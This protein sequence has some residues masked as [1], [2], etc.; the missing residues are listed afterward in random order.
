MLRILA[1]NARGP[2]LAIVAGLVF[3]KPALAARGDSAGP[4]TVPTIAPIASPSPVAAPSPSVRPLPQAAGTPVAA[5]AGA[6]APARRELKKY[7]TGYSAKIR[8]GANP[9]AHLADVIF[10]AE[11]L[12]IT[13]QTDGRTPTEFLIEIRGKRAG[14]TRR[15]LYHGTREIRLD[16]Q[17]RFVYP[18]RLSAALTQ[19][20]LQEVLVNG[21]VRKE[22]IQVE[23]TEWLAV[24][25]FR[26][27]AVTERKAYSVSP[28]I[29]ITSL[30][31]AQDRMD[32]LSEILL[33]VKLSGTLSLGTGP[34][35]LGGNV[36]FNALPLK[37]D[38]NDLQLRALGAN[39]RLGYALPYL[40]APWSLKLLGGIYFNTTFASP[41]TFGYQNVAGPQLFPVLSRSFAD[42]SVLGGY[43]KFSPV[44]ASF[45]LLSFSSREVA[46]GLFY[47]FGS[48][49]GAPLS[50]SL[51]Y[52][53]L[54]LSYG[55]VTARS[56]ALTLGGAINF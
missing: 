24:R 51:D 30:S 3:G 39:L 26:P 40:R 23:V 19:L 53:D 41:A 34:F 2:L 8:R 29:G 10:D 20:T 44:A 15:N 16:E 52:A 22:V 21:E 7:P 55:S 38:R 33:T 36:F 28:G 5:P 43:L 6:V 25:A 27:G 31:Y 45:S 32:S 46:G 47:V 50:L 54:R 49:G 37:K 1:L 18:L 12:E 4:I 35:D 11:P 48:R 9:A 56:K 13:A 17:G 42:R 14:T